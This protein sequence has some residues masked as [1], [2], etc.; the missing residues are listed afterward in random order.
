LTGGE[1][2]AMVLIDSLARM[3]PGV[4]KEMDSVIND[5]FF[6]GILDYPNYTRPSVFKGLAVPKQLLSGNHRK[7]ENWRKEQAYIA[8]KKKRPDLLKQNKLKYK[9]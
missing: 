8:T 1:L 4:V 6:N 5:S 2:P 3:L 9:E 7:I